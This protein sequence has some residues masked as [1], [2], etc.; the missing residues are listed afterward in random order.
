MKA[1]MAPL[2]YCHGTSVLQSQP[3]T[4]VWICVFLLT[5]GIFSSVSWPPGRH[6]CA[7]CFSIFFYKISIFFS[8]KLLGIFYY[9]CHLYI[10]GHEHRIG[11]RWVAGSLAMYSLIE[12][13]SSAAGCQFEIFF[14]LHQSHEEILLSS[15]GRAFTLHI[16]M[17]SPLTFDFCVC[18][19]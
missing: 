17:D 12:A 9:C 11:Y 4:V 19:N 5:V 2:L 15:R 3:F 7:G 10:P 13:F 18:I 8:H 16:V 14:S 1:P 6:F